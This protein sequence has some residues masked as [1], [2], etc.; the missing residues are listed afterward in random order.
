MSRSPWD[1]RRATISHYSGRV[2]V[3]A[4][5]WGPVLAELASPL[6]AA[7]AT[8]PAE[9]ILDLGCGVGTSYDRLPRAGRYVG[10]DHFCDMLTAARS[11]HPALR[12]V[13]ADATRLPFGDASFDL[14]FA[15]FML[16]HVR[17]QWRAL[18]EV[19]RVLK[20]G[21]RLGVATWGR[22]D[23]GGPAFTLF[24]SALQEEEAPDED[25]A[26]PPVWTEALASVRALEEL[27]A[28]LGF[29]ALRIWSDTPAW[30]WEPERLLDYLSGLGGTARRLEQLAPIARDRCRARAASELARL[31]RESLTWRPEIIFA[32]A[33]RSASQGEADEA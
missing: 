21:G 3:F 25:P 20:P 28:A 26:P 23:R 22:Q 30:T 6:F 15:G 7:L 17:E 12:P 29:R 31:D 16:H 9:R 14:V 5:S 8:C 27:T 10:V 19:Y 32:L 33:E 11:T 1:P 13:L 4:T 2:P 18:G 24:E